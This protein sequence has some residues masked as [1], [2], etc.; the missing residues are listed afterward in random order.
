MSE[1]GSDN[2]GNKKALIV[3]PY[4]G[5]LGGGERYM[6]Q[7]ASLLQVHGYETYFA[8]DNDDHIVFLAKRLGINLRKPKLHPEISQFYFQNQPLKMY[9][10]TKRYDLIFYLSDGSIPLLGG[11]K[12][13]IHMQVPFHEVG[14]RSLKNKFKLKTIDQIIVN[15]KFTKKIIDQEYGVDSL[16]V[17]P[18]VKLPVK[19]TPK[20]K[21]I[22]LSVG[23]F[24][25][26][27]NVKKQDVLIKAFKQLSPK[28]PNWRLILVGGAKE[29]AMR[30]VQ[31]LQEMATGFPIEIKPNLTYAELQ[32]LY[33]QATIYWHAA[34]YGVDESHHPELVEHFG[35]TTVEALNYHCL[36][37]VVP[38][39][40][41]KEIL[42]EI[43]FHWKTLDE[44]VAKT[45][46]FIQSP[47][48]PPAF[49]DYS[50]ARFNQAII[51]LID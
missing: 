9:L 13:I 11:K 3:S 33:Q 25:P 48:P 43:T 19:I 26:S 39:G 18:P 2:P 17:Y 35:I 49:K 46:N 10:A 22:I 1:P 7:I 47:P 20:K 36:P 16:V 38:F 14:G 40:G 15:S 21:L 37:L 31:Q 50:L 28:I 27:L 5:H 51:S 41:Q 32:K 29:G 6:L 12:N 30:W 4:L 42:P 23:R 45:L 24:E 44:L 34:G 8:W